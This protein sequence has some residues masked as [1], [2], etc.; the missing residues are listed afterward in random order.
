MNHKMYVTVIY[1]DMDT[2]EVSFVSGT[3]TG[4]LPKSHDDL[5]SIAHGVIRNSEFPA[6][7]TPCNDGDQLAVTGVIDLGPATND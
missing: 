5:M 3:V 4:P 7:Y 1:K 2:R 6:G